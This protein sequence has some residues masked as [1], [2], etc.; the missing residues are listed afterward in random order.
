MKI[1]IPLYSNDSNINNDLS[2][3]CQEKGANFYLKLDWLAKENQIFFLV[4]PKETYILPV[5]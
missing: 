2:S 1:S 5:G 4:T 3:E